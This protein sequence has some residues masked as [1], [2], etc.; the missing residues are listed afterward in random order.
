M[1]RAGKGV[2][3]L[4]CLA[5]LLTGCGAGDAQPSAPSSPSLS[6]EPT[7]APE[8][9]PPVEPPAP[10]EGPLAQTLELWLAEDLPLCGALAELAEDYAARRPE[11]ELKTVVYASE[12]ELLEALEWGRPDLLLCGEAAAE[13][14]LDEGR[15]GSVSLPAETPLL[16][17][18][19]PACAA[20]SLIPLCAEAAV[21][22]LKEENLP[23]LENCDTLETLG[24]LASDYARSKERPFF[25][26]D[27][28][29]QLIACALAQKGSPFYTRRELDRGS[30][31]YRGVYNLLADAA[32]EG[33]LVSLN[34]PVLSAVERGDL[35]CGVCG[36]RMLAQAESGDLAVLPL[37]PMAGCEAMTEARIWGLAVSAEADGERAADFLSWLLAQD[38]TALAALEAGLV[39]AAKAESAENSVF[40]GLAL[41]ARS[42][43]CFL[44]A[45]DSAYARGGVEFER[46]FRAALALLG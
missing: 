8:T 24:R 23:L 33:G 1:K 43:R 14:L 15:L 6:S 16:F 37:P 18:G 36:S 35:I 5:L 12:T 38:R 45:P 34:E 41:V 9:P 10:T 2:A 28:F 30:E 40:S 27:S 7:D 39:P 32:F 19:A 4:L 21:L 22:V 31:A 3:L 17:R 46:S 25:S 20:E 44:P 11:L 26:A 29:A 42:C 13:E